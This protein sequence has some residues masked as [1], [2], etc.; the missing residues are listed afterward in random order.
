[1]SIDETEA[2]RRQLLAEI[3]ADPTGRAALEAKHGKVWDTDQLS[4]DFTVIGFMAPVVA[5]IRKSDHQKGSLY[6][7]ANPRFYFSFSA[8]TD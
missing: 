3:N 6:F 5:V 4:E 7:Q 8:H 2:P 1:M